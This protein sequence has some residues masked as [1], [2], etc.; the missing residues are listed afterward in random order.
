MQNNILKLFFLICFGSHR[1]SA[2]VDKS[3]PSCIK[4]FSK[5]DAIGFA[6]VT[7]PPIHKLK[8]GF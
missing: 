4:A 6:K 2:D 8:K 7:K 1:Y 3:S 5:V